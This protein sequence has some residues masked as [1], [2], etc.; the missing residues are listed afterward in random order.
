MYSLSS[1]MYNHNTFS[2]ETKVTYLTRQKLVTNA[3]GQRQLRLWSLAIG[4][5]L[6]FNA[7]NSKKKS[8]I[9]YA[10]LSHANRT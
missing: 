8:R 3:G 9:L 2:G 7:K 10:D 1:E 5:A 4:P 6:C